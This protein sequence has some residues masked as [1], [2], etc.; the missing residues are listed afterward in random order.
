VKYLGHVSYL[1]ITR[2]KGVFELLSPDTV[3]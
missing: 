3:V 1:S 2:K